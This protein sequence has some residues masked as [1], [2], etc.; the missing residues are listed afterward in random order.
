MNVERL[1]AIAAALR[2]ELEQTNQ[3]GLLGTLVS[4]LTNQVNAPQDA[5][6]QQQVVQTLNSLEDR[7]AVAASNDY[8][9]TWRQVLDEI[10]ASE[11]LGNSL[12][13]SLRETFARNQITPAIARDQISALLERSQRFSAALDQVADGLAYLRIGQDELEPGEAEVSV[14]IPRPAVR[15]DLPTLGSEFGELQKILGPFLEL[16]GGS[17]PPLKVKTISSSDFVVYLAMAPGAALSVATALDKILDVYKKLLEV[18]RLRQEMSDQGVTDSDLAAVDARAN[19]MMAEG[20]KAIAEEMVSA[21][22]LDDPGRANELRIELR[23]SLNALANRIDHGYHI[24]VRAEPDAA[25]DES[26]DMDDGDEARRSTLAQI[27]EM[28]SRIT[29]INTTGKPIL[30]LP[31]KQTPESE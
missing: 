26:D 19:S 15:E 5:S 27:A 29:F 6:Q 31:E 17:R 4:A 28:S 30:S 11:L 25:A 21:A 20:T 13:Q 10:G 2:L 14:G 23:L 22:S 24:D 16:S 3:V 12:G 18:R 8:P 1:H 7:L 9:A